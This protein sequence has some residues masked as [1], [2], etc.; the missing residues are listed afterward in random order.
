MVSSVLEVRAGTAA[1]EG[2]R[3]GDRMSITVPQSGD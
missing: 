3:T 1:T 2:L